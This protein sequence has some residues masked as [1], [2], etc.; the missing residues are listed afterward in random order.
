[1][2][3][4]LALFLVTN[5][6]VLLVFGVVLG[7]LVATGIVPP[8]LA[9]AYGPLL[10]LCAAFG[11]GGALVSLALSKEVARRAVGAQ[12]IDRPRDANEAWLLQTVTDL[13]KRAGIGTPE[14]AIYDSPEPN[15]FAT[16][17]RRD[18]ALV[19]VS[20]GLLRR[21]SR[22]GVEGVLGHEVAH[23]ANGDM[24]TMTLLQGVLNTFVLFFSR[25]AGNL[26]DAALRGNSRE[27]RQSYGYGPGYYLA[28]VVAEL[29]L[30]LLATV[31]V[32]WFSR[33]REFRADAGGARLAGTTSMLT[34]LEQ[35]AASHGEEGHLP[36]SLSAFGIRPGGGGLLAGLFRSHP[37][38][39]VRITRLRER[40]R[41]EGLD[42]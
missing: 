25:I 6:A 21:M 40:A 36:E 41:G 24:V 8:D 12:V 9:Q 29:V 26:I 37:P 2:M 14:V 13:A 11:F 20:T 10:A 19:A 23:V 35:L 33:W 16:G 28:T 42:L 38:L 18:A 3:L 30:G 15:A 1:M 31:I 22:D 5:L 34:A 17:A 4:R 32:M 27:Q 7:V 39:D